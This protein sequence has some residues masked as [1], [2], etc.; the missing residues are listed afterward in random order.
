MTTPTGT[1]RRLS[2]H[3]AA[4]QML[5]RKWHAYIGMIIAPTVLLFAMTGVLQVYE[6]HEAHTGYAPPAVVA[7]LGMLHKKQ[8]YR[9]GRRPQSQ[10][11]A[12]PSPGPAPAASRPASRPEAKAQRL[13]TTFLKAFFAL[14]SIGLIISTITGVW[15]TLRQPL[16]RMRHILLL[17]VGTVVPLVLSCLSQ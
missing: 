14:A 17:V 8:L 2:R 7:K 13:P 9:E 16:H 12:K 15:M 4:L 6:L 5:L 11:S 10:P 3:P 1:A